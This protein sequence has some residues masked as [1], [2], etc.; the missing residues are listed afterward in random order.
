MGHTPI[1]KWP[2][3]DRESF[4][5]HRAKEAY[6]HGRVT[7][8]RFEELVACVLGGGHLSERLDPIPKPIPLYWPRCPECGAHVD[9]CGRPEQNAE[10]EW[11][12][13][14]KLDRN[15]SMASPASGH[16]FSMTVA[17]LDAIQEQRSYEVSGGGLPFPPSV[18]SGG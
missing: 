9:C 8:E 12:F 5:L 10:R 15:P 17:G 1:V 2:P 3:P 11:W 16:V 14:C 7:L 13:R 4:H 6:V 18:F